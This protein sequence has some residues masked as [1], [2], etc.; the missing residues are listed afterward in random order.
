MGLTKFQKLD[1]SLSIVVSGWDVWYCVYI[2]IL[3]I[4]CS[5]VKYVTPAN[6]FLVVVVVLSLYALLECHNYHC[7]NNKALFKLI[8]HV[9]QEDES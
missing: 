6:H 2:S 1:N 8:G 3:V 7:G 4:A 9:E 5:L